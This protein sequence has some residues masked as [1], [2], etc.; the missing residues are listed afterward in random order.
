MIEAALERHTATAVDTPEAILEL[1]R[2]TR[3]QTADQQ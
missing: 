2:E 1:D 3:R